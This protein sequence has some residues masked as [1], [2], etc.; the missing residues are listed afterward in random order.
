MSY[1]IR[2]LRFKQTLKIYFPKLGFQ[3][4]WSDQGC[5]VEVYGILGLQGLRH[6]PTRWVTGDESPRDFVGVTVIAN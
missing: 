5:Y 4:L 3:H 6:K 1:Q 2:F